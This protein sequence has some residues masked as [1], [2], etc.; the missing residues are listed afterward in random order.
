MKRDKSIVEIAREL[1][2]NQTPSE[3]FLWEHLR[4]RRLGGYRFNRQKPIIYET[5][6]G[7]RCFFIA[8]FYCAEKKLV[9]EVDGSIHAFTKYEDYQRDRVLREL[10]L[11][12]IRIKNDELVDIE[13]VKKKIIKQLVG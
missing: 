11:R 7:R 13:G 8:D 10:G 1:R 3:R 6:R 4:K 5:D 9:I 12:T 2:K